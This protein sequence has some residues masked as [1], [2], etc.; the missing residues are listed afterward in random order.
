MLTSLIAG[1]MPKPGQAPRE[2]D[3]RWGRYLAD[4]R[5]TSGWARMSHRETDRHLGEWFAPEAVVEAERT[6]ASAAVQFTVAENHQD[7]IC[8]LHLGLMQ[9]ALAQMRAPVTAD[10]PTVRRAQP[11][12]RMPLPPQRACQHG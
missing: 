5:P 7:V 1:M 2:S 4:S 11:M 9:G 3:P 8:Q 6:S 10:R 12:H